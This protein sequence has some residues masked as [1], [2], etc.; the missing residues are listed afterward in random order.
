MKNNKLIKLFF[1]VL[2]S[3][4]L[5]ILILLKVDFKELYRSI[6]SANY[7]YFIIGA[8]LVVLGILI[9]T[10]RW[11]II[12]G[13]YK[14]RLNY[15]R[16]FFLYW[17]GSFLNLF[18]PTSFGGDFYKYYYLDNTFSRGKRAQIVSSLLLDRGIGMYSS[19]ILGL[20]AFGILENRIDLIF[21]ISSVV[22]ALALILVI[23]FWQDGKIDSL[24]PINKLN[25][26]NKLFKTL[27]IFLNYRNPKEV[28]LTM[29]ISI[30]FSVICSLAIF[31]SF[32]AVNYR[33]NFGILLFT[34]PLINLTK[35]IPF[36]IDSVGVK[37]GFGIYIYSLYDIASEISLSAMLFSRVFNLFAS[38]IGGIVILFNKKTSDSAK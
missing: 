4:I 15:W 16:L 3:S 14:L 27:S 26:K 30:L 5:I 23:Y 37:E 9:S 31:V 38:L 8:S 17:S 18:L 10:A 34:V 20:T 12:L 1:R 22:I 13:G 2:V 29:I 33:I 7:I 28:L 21:R 11:Q 25:K 19:I 32:L 6:I 36:T 35:L 24:L